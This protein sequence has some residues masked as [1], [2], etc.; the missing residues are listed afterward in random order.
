MANESIQLP[1]V[2]GRYVLLKRLARGGM[3]EIF[4]AK[5]GDVS[6][7]ERLFVIKKILPELA[8]DAQFMKRFVEEAQIAIKLNH[9]NIAHVFEVGMVGDDL[10]LALEYVEGRDLRRI[11]SRC[12]KAGIQFPQDIALFIA[13]EVC[14]GLS[15]AHRRRDEQDRPL[16]LVHCDISPPNVLVS[17]EGEIKVIDFGVA[18]SALGYQEDDH[19]VGFGKLGYM[20]PEQLLKGRTVDQRADI[21]SAGVVLYEMLVGDRM[22][23]LDPNAEHRV[24]VRKIV[25]DPV[26]PP[27][28]R[29]MG[30]DPRLDD[31][32][33][34]AVAKDPE[35]R[36]RIASEFR[37]DIQRV[38][39][40]INPTITG[41]DLGD[42]LRELFQDEL[43]LD[44]ETI[45]QAHAMDLAPYREELDGAIEATVSYAV[46][47]L[48]EPQAPPP[49]PPLPGTARQE[50]TDRAGLLVPA[51]AQPTR[52]SRGRWIV[53]L[54]VI[55]LILGIGFL[56]A[57]MFK[58]NTKSSR[59]KAPA[60]MAHDLGRDAT[61]PAGPRVVSLTD[62]EVTDSGRTPRSR[63]TRTSRRPTRR[64]VSR[65]RPRRTV[66][67]TRPKART[68]KPARTQP[69]SRPESTAATA[70]RV[71]AKFLRVSREYRRFK[72]QFGPRL[73]SKWQ[74]ILHT[75]AYG[76]ASRYARVDAMLDNFR[77]RM[78]KIR[79]QEGQ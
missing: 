31:L 75:A 52:S 4:L 28:Q 35:D 48:W 77:A 65:A 71:E 23:D 17:F 19:Q 25:L 64:W 40:D 54:A 16:D 29:V 39:S 30:I 41:D 18:R 11:L 56:V 59:S 66:T 51:T 9:I 68:R 69:E 73:E 13:R 14:N 43:Q 72:R 36:Y 1:A 50:P 21:Y 15:Y 26:T 42:F 76:G 62:A 38:L 34:K 67:R 46:T 27:S 53:A 61:V 22:V 3:G 7:F 24:N 57:A 49:P 20:A 78:A 44:R 55:G 74:V 33:L 45:R 5:S 70:A 8:R 47:T 6:G 37:D 32:V 2:F 60:R 79:R 63:R 12:Y 10:F 58:G